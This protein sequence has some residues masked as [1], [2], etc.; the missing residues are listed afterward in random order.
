LGTGTSTPGSVTT[1]HS[2]LAGA[3]I[4]GLSSGKPQLVVRVTARATT[5]PIK[6]LTVTLPSGLHFAQNRRQVGKG[7]TLA[8]RPKSSL[9]LKHG[10]LVVVFNRPQRTVSLTISAPALSETSSLVKR[11]KAIVKFNRTRPHAKKKVLE[12]RLGM[13]L[14]DVKAKSASVHAVLRVS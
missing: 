3:S 12:L 8:H 2:G 9:S 11:V 14:T 10:R 1:G 5:A 13:R 4:S 7:V 6:S